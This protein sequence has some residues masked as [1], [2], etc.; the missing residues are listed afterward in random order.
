MHLKR[1]EVKL[2]TSRHFLIN[3]HCLLNSSF[4]FKLTKFKKPKFKQLN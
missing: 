1:H 2:T 3:R 4:K